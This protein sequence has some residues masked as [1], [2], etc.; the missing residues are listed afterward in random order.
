[1]HDEAEL[2]VALAAGADLVGVN[3]RDLRSFEVDL[4]TSERLAACVPAGSDVL[5]VAESGIATHADVQRLSRAGARAF[6]VGES[7]MRQP[8]VA[9]A[10]AKLRGEPSPAA[11]RGAARRGRK[12]GSG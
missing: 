9:A 6:L 1:V 12:E 7:L 4:A 3:N 11:Q 2:E 10:L 5:L 8:D